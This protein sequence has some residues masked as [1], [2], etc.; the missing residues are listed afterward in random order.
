MQ[1]L[2]IISIGR[3]SRLMLRPFEFRHIYHMSARSL[4][5]VI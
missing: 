2:H 3:P 1:Q 5:V 4:L